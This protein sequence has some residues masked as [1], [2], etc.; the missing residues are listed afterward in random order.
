MIVVVPEAHALPPE[1][2]VGADRSPYLANNQQAVDEELFHDIIPFIEAHYNISDNPRRR[3]IAGLSMG[4]LQ[5]IEIG[6][7]HLGY[8]RRIGAFSP[9]MM[10]PAALSEDFENALRDPD[11]INKNQ[12]LFEIVIGD[13]DQIVGEDVREFEDQ[14]KQANVQHTYTVLPGGT[15][16]MFVWRPALYDFLQKVFKP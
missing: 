1:D 8:F 7:V 16:S 6:I 2:I 13:D 10:R 4:G 15:H 14:L 3:A 5:S 12:L 11:K 9:G